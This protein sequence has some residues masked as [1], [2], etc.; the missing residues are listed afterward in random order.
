MRWREFFSLQ[1][2]T[3][4]LRKC[5]VVVIGHWFDVISRADVPTSLADMMRIS[6]RNNVNINFTEFNI[7][8]NVGTKIMV[9]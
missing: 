4:E 9:K 8:F 5:M 2:H 6:V 7:D 1:A 3:S